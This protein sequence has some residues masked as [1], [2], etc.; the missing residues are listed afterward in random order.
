MRLVSERGCYAALLLEVRMLSGCTCA[1]LLHW[2]TSPYVRRLV[3]DRS[4]EG[5]ELETLSI[6]ARKQIT[7]THL[8]RVAYPDTLKP[9][10]TFQVRGSL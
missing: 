9:Q 7:R 5:L 10:V 1:G 3:F 4:T 6:L 8:S 2:F